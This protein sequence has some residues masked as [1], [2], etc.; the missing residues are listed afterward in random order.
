MGLAE[1]RAVSAYQTDN[2][3]SW[4]PKFDSLCGF[5]LGL[6]VQWEQIAKDG[7]AN[8]YPAIFEKNYY[9]PLAQALGSI[10]GDDIGRTGFKNKFNKIVIKNDNKGNFVSVSIVDNKLILNGSP[11]AV[12]LDNA[13]K[14]T[15]KALIKNLEQAL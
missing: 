5:D 2:F 1:K 14:E 6:E 11:A 3:I 10:C 7:W 4:K 13:S 8:D 15:T 9:E 12:N